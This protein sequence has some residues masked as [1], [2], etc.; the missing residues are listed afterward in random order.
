MIG[1]FILIVYMG[2]VPLV[3]LVWFIQVHTL[4][5]QKQWMID[6]LLQWCMVGELFNLAREAQQENKL[7]WFRAQQWYFFGV[8][9]FFFHLR[10]GWMHSLP[11]VILRTEMAD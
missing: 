10:Y 6:C 11:V 4:I 9:T 3:A 5:R 2:H 8:A 1:S 7:P